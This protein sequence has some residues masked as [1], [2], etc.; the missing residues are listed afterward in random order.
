MNFECCINQKRAF[1]KYL[2]SDEL[3]LLSRNKYD[4]N[5]K[6][7]EV[8]C[9]AGSR[10]EGLICL[11]EGKVKMTVTA[12][13]GNE[14]IVRLLKAIDFIAFRA[15]LAEQACSASHVCLEDS[16]VCIIPKEDFFSILRSNTELSK[17]IM[18]KFANDLILKDHRLMNLTQNRMRARVA[19]AL[20]LIHDVY[21]TDKETGYL[22]IRMKRSD[23][24]SL[25]SMTTDN[26]IRE[27]SALKRENL[28]EIHNKDI[29]IRDLNKLKSIS[30]LN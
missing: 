1:F 8:I 30:N 27:L 11:T 15:L 28:I 13:N 22:S 25:S 4:V 10:P 26:A 12:R 7:G 17:S 6:A 23:L 29:R 2:N 24:G 21:G 16:L 18:R 3:N 9:K 19:E 14:Q 20:L 5:Y